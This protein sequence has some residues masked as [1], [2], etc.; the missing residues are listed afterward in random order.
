[1]Y[2][3][4]LIKCTCKHTHVS[5]HTH[6]HTH[7]HTDSEQQFYVLPMD[8]ATNTSD[9]ETH[10]ELLTSAHPLTAKVDRNLQVFKPSPRATHFDLPKDFFNLTLEEIKKEQKQRY[11]SRTSYNTLYSV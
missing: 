8:K 7:T 6:T 3:N 2:M 10:R 9:L 4:A 5:T 1:M 11:R